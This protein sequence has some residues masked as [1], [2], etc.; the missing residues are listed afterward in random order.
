MSELLARPRR[1]GI[2]ASSARTAL[3]VVAEDWL[4]EVLAAAWR[5]AGGLPLPAPEHRIAERIV[6]TVVPDLLVLDLD[7]LDEPSLAWVRAL[8]A[9]G[10]AA[11]PLVLLGQRVPAGLEGG[12]LLPKPIEPRK[13][14]LAATRLL[15]QGELPLAASG[16]APIQVGPL[17]V[18]GSAPLLCLADAG[19]ERLL[20]LPRREHALL[21]ALLEP[22]LGVRSREELRASAWGG[23]T[24][25]LRTV[26]QYVRRLRASLAPL[27]LR[28]LVGT[29]ATAG[30]RAD[31]DAIGS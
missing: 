10:P 8:L 13:F 26:D 9:S 31:L 27:G 30:Y 22:P 6:G 25:A 1:S 4:R 11:P 29:V 2:P 16:A 20:T 21:R 5:S 3:L 19:G 15:R 17:R 28:D 7:G 12:V 14:V 23:E 18:D 24:V